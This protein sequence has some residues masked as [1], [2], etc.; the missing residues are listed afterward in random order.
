VRRLFG[1][2]YTLAGLDLLLHRAG[3]L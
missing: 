1:V 2:A 3:C